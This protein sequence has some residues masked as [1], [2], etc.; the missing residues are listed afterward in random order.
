MLP[1]T[2]TRESS[3]STPC[4]L[5]LATLISV[6]V[7]SDACAQNPT[8]NTQT[9]V[10]RP[11]TTAQT[12]RR[13]PAAVRAPPQAPP[14]RW[15][16]V[17]DRFTGFFVHKTPE[18]NVTPTPRPGP[19]D[20]PHPPHPAA[21]HSSH[22]SDLHD[23]P[24]SGGQGQGGTPLF[25]AHPPAGSGSGAQPPGIVQRKGPDG[26]S[27]YIRHGSDG[28]RQVMVERPDGS[29][30]FATPHGA[31]YVQRPWNFQAQAFDR[32]TYLEG[33][34]VTQQFYRQYTY[35][36]ITLD[37]Y[38]PQRFYDPQ[39]YQWALR[40][41]TPPVAASWNYTTNPAPWYSHYRGYFTPEP[42]YT[43]ALAWLTDYLIANSLIASWNAHQSATQPAAHTAAQPPTAPAGQ[44]TPSPTQSSAPAQ[45]AEASPEVTPEVKQKVAEEV[46]RQIREESD[47]AKAN[48]QNS[49]L[50][51]GKGG[52][53]SELD[54]RDLHTF[55]VS[56]DLDLVDQEGRRCT[57]SAGD[58]VQVI[59]RANRSNNTAEATVLSAKP[60]ECERAAD[61]A[62]NLTDLQEMSNHMRESVDQGLANR[63]SKSGVQTTAA[64]FAASPPAPDPDA[65]QQIEQQ[66]KIAAAEG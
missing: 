37:A 49:E 55:V 2:R 40:S 52:I 21:D 54:E 1:T 36:G 15:Q 22:L 59:S 30:V 25:P 61:V 26:S 11:T 9:P 29:R 35:N 44:A 33:G 20:T 53:V 63:A 47:E 13:P 19:R 23:V 18:H 51:P 27:M 12:Q 56:S 17:K 10:H 39:V 24:G 64:A 28:S 58:V 42:S 48:A 43:N 6:L 32:R 4:A 7:A 8:P 45:G 65:A 66:Q 5:A 46:S 3:A 34:K 62:I 41:R 14:T 57:I 16:N 60:G 50:P 38:A 31:S